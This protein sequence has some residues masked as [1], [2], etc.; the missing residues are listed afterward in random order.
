MYSERC[1][2]WE[3]NGVLGFLEIII[4]NICDACY[5]LALFSSLE[6]FPDAGIF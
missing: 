4:A 2:I 3:E 5:V 1:Y 6:I